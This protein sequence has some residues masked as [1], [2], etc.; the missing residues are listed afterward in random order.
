MKD[1]RRKGCLRGDI[2]CFSKKSPEKHY[3]KNE[4]SERAEV[5]ILNLKLKAS[6]VV[7]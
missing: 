3:V 1:A 2:L 7:F 5:F 6:D 4:S